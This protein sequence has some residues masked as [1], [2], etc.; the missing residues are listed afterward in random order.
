MVGLARVRGAS[1]RQTLI[2]F[3]MRGIFRIMPCRSHTILWLIKMTKSVRWRWLNL[4]FSANSISAQQSTAPTTRTPRTASSLP[5][6]ACFNSTMKPQKYAKCFSSWLHRSHLKMPIMGIMVAQAGKKTCHGSIIVRH[7]RIS[8]SNQA[9]LISLSLSISY[10]T[11]IIKN[12]YSCF[13]TR[14]KNPCDYQS[15]QN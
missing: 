8:L 5:T 9:E 3:L 15:H 2:N 7:H 1:S 11:S 10:S 6:Y 12:P 14:I 13:L 4:T